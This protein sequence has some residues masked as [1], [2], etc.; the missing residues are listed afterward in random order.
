MNWPISDEKNTVKWKILKASWHSMIRKWNLVLGVCRFILGRW[1]WNGHLLTT[2]GRKPFLFIVQ[3]P[4]ETDFNSYDSFTLNSTYNEV[5]FN[6]TSAITK[7]NLCTKY[8]PFT[9]NDVILNEKPPIMKG[10]L[11]IFFFIIGRVE[12]TWKM[13][14]KRPFFCDTGSAHSL[15]GFPRR[16]LQVIMIVLVG[17]WSWKGHSLVILRKPLL[18]YSDFL[19]DRASSW[20]D[21][22]CG[23]MVFKRQYVSDTVEASANFFQVS[24]ETEHQL[25]YRTGLV[26][27]AVLLRWSC[28]GCIM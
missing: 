24:L 15:C 6:E 14:L 17:R 13:A 27:M 10:K 5:A 1:S 28:N 3:G 21:N 4:W 23:K 11:C 25:V 7:E 8:F 26:N 19:G 9:Y 18:F 20:Y 12:C 2:L 16:Q 22:L